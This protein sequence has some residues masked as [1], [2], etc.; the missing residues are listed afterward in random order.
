M[1]YDYMEQTVA[2]VALEKK[3]LQVCSSELYYDL[4]NAIIDMTDE[5]IEFVISCNGDYDK[6]TA[7]NPIYNS[8]ST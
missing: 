7:D 6:E 4:A 8:W 3:A 1:L 5:E 2:R